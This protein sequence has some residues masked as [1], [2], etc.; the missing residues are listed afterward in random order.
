M[1]RSILG[2]EIDRTL[3][4]LFGAGPVPAAAEQR[5]R[6]RSM[7]LGQVAI[8]VERVLS[9]GPRFGKGFIRRHRAITRQHV[10]TICKTRVRERIPR[11]QGHRLL[12]AVQPLLY[13]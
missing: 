1:R 8:D 6:E 5:V 4:F 7:S 2:I 10:V 3:E 9:L 13:S 11:L 12:E